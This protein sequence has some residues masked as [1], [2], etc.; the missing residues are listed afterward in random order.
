ME[1]KREIKVVKKKMCN[2]KLVREKKF[3]GYEYK[4]ILQL[5]MQY[6]YT[7]F[8]NLHIFFMMFFGVFLQIVLYNKC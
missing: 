2:I 4:R 5:F 1:K 8:R 7:F 6:C 3:K